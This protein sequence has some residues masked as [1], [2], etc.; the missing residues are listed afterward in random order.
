MQRMPMQE[1]L[2]G[3]TSG[4]GA[5]FYRCRSPELLVLSR[6]GG[7]YGIPAEVAREA[8]SHH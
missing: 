2:M 8:I 6:G 4:R 5:H 7:Q 3:H 1:C